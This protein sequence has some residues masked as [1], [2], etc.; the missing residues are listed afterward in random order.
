MVSARG[1]AGWQILDNTP[2]TKHD[3]IATAAICF[4]ITLWN[5]VM[6]YIV[7]AIALVR[8]EIRKNYRGSDDKARS[9]EKRAA[10]WQT[11]LG[12]DY[13][14]TRWQAGRRSRR[15][16]RQ[17]SLVTSGRLLILAGRE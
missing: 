8:W 7:Q 17:P 13:R 15:R 16:A 5:A 11:G 1:I 4:D 2:Q 10:L 6:A 9:N 14:R 3:R 12:D